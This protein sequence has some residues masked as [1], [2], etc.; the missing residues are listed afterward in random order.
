M[1]EAGRPA[2]P[3]RLLRR[4]LFSAD[5]CTADGGMNNAR[6]RT[7]AFSARVPAHLCVAVSL[8]EQHPACWKP[9]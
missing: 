7:V 2:A 3:H 5:S 8:L 9:V 4:L 6:V 1:D